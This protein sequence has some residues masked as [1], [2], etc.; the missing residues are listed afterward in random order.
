MSTVDREESSPAFMPLRSSP[1][2]RSIR[3]LTYVSRRLQFMGPTVLLVTLVNLGVLLWGI[4]AN[5]SYYGYQAPL[6]I[7]N[8]VIA[9][10]TIAALGFFEALRKRGDAIFQ[11]V[12]DEL[13]W[14]VGHSE[15]RGL[16]LREAPSERPLLEARVVL[17][18]FSAAA[19][20][21]LVPGRLGGAAYALLNLVVA[22]AAVALIGT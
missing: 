10:A 21:P 22:V 7:I 8:I 12:S 2:E 16:S 19:E 1:I 18:T 11:E 3:E 14:Y 6:A 15:S 9:M 13:Q 4:G 5:A 17:R 20:L